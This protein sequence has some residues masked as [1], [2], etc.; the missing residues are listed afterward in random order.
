MLQR[1]LL[2]TASYRYELL[3]NGLRASYDAARN[4]I[5]ANEPQ[6]LR[7]SGQSHCDAFHQNRQGVW[8]GLGLPPCGHIS[9]KCR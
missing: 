1:F 6:L 3:D 8:P 2:S 9:A 5:R 7:T 4:C